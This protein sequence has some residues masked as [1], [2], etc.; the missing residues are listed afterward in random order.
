[1]DNINIDPGN[2]MVH[3]EEADGAID[4]GYESYN[5]FFTDH[6]TGW[7]ADMWFPRNSQWELANQDLDDIEFSDITLPSTKSN[8]GTKTNIRLSEFSLID[9]KLTFKFKR[10]PK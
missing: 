7:G 2:R 5:P 3:L 8:S 4:I 1:M 9:S 6:I 10:E